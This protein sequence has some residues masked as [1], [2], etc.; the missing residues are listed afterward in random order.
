MQPNRILIP[1]NLPKKNEEPQLSTNKWPHLWPRTQNDAAVKLYDLPILTRTQNWTRETPTKKKLKI[2]C[3]TENDM[4]FVTPQN[5]HGSTPR[6]DAPD[7]CTSRRSPQRHCARQ[8]ALWPQPEGKWRCGC[9]KIWKWGLPWYIP[10][11]NKN[12]IQS[13]K[14]R[15]NQRIKNGDSFAVQLKPNIVPESSI[16]QQNMRS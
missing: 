1:T 10:K 3:L 9:G 7:R 14:M 4:F 6:I 12:G 8:W 15:I 13:A 16:C 11:T 2:S 5:S